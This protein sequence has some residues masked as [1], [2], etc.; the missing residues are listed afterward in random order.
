MGIAAEVLFA[1]VNDKFQA[2][3]PGWA[4]LAEHAASAA[5]RRRA[6]PPRHRSARREHPRAPRQR[7][8]R[9]GDGRLVR[10]LS[11]ELGASTEAAAPR[12]LRPV[13]PGLRRHPRAHARSALRMNNV[14]L[15]TARSVMSILSPL[16]GERSSGWVLVRATGAPATLPQNSYAV[17]VVGG[18]VHFDALVKTLPESTIDPA[19]TLVP[20]ASVLAGGFTNLAEGTE[21]HLG[22]A[23]R[24]HRAGRDGRDAGPH[25]RHE[26]EG[27]RRRA[28]DEALRAGR[29]GD[30]G[31]GTSSR[32]R[33]A[34]SRRSFSPGTRARS[35]RM[36]L[37]GR[38][39]PRS[40]SGSTGSSRSSLPATT[41]PTSGA[42]KRS[43]CSRGRRS[44][45][46]SEARWTRR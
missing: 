40:S 1:T 24:G 2:S 44:S 30:G 46:P 4:P 7:L 3:G 21:L 16:M 36:S 27:L 26:R 9:G 25:R 23:H 22:P 29:L 34:I 8:R 13:R 10:R 35:R 11:R 18:Q 6:D 20:A 15:R 14:I 37:R 41:A 38:A 12:L 28:A 32:R 43:T 39:G 19:G 33:S 31:A 5:R 42:T 45:S 17:P